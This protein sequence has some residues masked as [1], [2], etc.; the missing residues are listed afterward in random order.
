MADTAHPW[1]E[2][3]DDRTSAGTVA[4][5]ITRRNGALQPK[6]GGVKTALMKRNLSS[7]VGAFGYHPRVE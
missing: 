4:S 5:W 1:A 2:V 7:A 3:D 6:V